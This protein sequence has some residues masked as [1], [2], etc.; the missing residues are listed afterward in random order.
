MNDGHTIVLRRL[1]WF[2]IR[3]FDT[4]EGDVVCRRPV[5]P[6]M[7]VVALV[8]SLPVGAVVSWMARGFPSTWDDLAL[9]VLSLFFLAGCAVSVN[10]WRQVRLGLVCTSTHIVYRDCALL[11]SFELAIPYE[12]ILATRVLCKNHVLLIRVRD[13]NPCAVVYYRRRWDSDSL[14]RKPSLIAVEGPWSLNDLFEARRR[15]DFARRS[16]R[17]GTWTARTTSRP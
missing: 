13:T 3:S 12:A 5:L 16:Y 17:V 10:I 4:S 8:G 2:S 7:L 9:L 1:S 15:L 11:S 6:L 14:R